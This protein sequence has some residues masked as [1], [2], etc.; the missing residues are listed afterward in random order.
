VIPIFIGS[1]FFN[2]KKSTEL[3][4]LLIY[5]EFSFAILHGLKPRGAWA[6]GEKLN[7]Y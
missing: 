2:I 6:R 5:K 7:I 3:L 1:N 4:N